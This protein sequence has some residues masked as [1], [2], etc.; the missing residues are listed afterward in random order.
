MTKAEIRERDREKRARLVARRVSERVC[1]WCSSPLPEGYPWQRCEACREK[2]IPYYKDYYEYRKLSGA[3]TLCGR[4]AEEGKTRCAACGA[5]QRE[6]YREKREAGLCPR[7][8]RS[9]VPGKSMCP[10]CAEKHRLKKR[11]R[12]AKKRMEAGRIRP[13]ETAE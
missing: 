2:Q 13:D 7:C 9:A 1:V 12:D 4:I 5:K 11:E 8:G 3:C 10:E 6:R